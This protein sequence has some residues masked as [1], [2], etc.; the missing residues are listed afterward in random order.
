MVTKTAKVYKTQFWDFRGF[1]DFRGFRDHH[2]FW[3]FDDHD[4]KREWLGTRVSHVISFL[5][6]AICFCSYL[7]W[8]DEVKYKIEAG[9]SS[10][11]WHLQRLNIEVLDQIII[12]VF[13]F[14]I[15]I[16]STSRFIV[17]VVV[18]LTIKIWEHGNIGQQMIIM[19]KWPHDTNFRLYQGYL[20]Q[21]VLIWKKWPYNT[22]FRLHQGYWAIGTIFG[23][24]NIGSTR[25]TLVTDIIFGKIII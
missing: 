9:S 25:G 12:C 15:A 4:C 14:G 22:Y 16:R 8:W 10:H 7:R 13:T 11:H 2:I 21:L 3:G 17:V 23:K 19:S 6:I 5:N 18:V 24:M 20:R 1:H